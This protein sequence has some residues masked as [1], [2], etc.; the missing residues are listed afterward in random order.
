M[1]L[2]ANN[3]TTFINATLTLMDI[4]EMILRDIDN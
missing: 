4:K 1:A 3:N 2:P